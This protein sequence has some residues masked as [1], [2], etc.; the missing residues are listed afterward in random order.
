[1]RKLAT[2]ALAF[3]AAVFVA[4]YAFPTEWLFVAAILTAIPG[5]LLILFHRRWLTPVILALMFFS[6]GLVH[7]RLYVGRTLERAA[8]FDR[9]DVSVEGRLLDY[10]D[11][12]DGYTRLL[13]RIEDGEL[14]RFKAV[15]YDNDHL[16][17]GALP[18]DRILFEGSVRTADTLYGEPYDNYIVN[19]VFFRLTIKSG[20]VLTP[21]GFSLRT[22][23]V[24]LRRL[25]CSR[26]DAVFPADVRP[27]LKAL[28]LGDRDDFYADDALYVS[29]TRSGLMHVVAVS[30]LH[31]AFL[32]GLL[33]FILGRGKVGTLVS[34][35][36]V[37]LFVLVTGAGK[38]AVRAGFM[39]TLLLLA[40]ILRRENDPLTS[41]SAVLAL[42]LCASPFAAR[43]V[44]LQLSYTAMAGILC[45]FERIESAFE[46]HVPERFLCRPVRYL[47]ASVA[48]SL[49]VMPFTVPLTALHFGYVPLLSPISNPLCLWAVS[50]SFCGAWL[51]T[52]LS[53]IP[54]LGRAAGWLFAWPVRWLMLCARL[55]AA[56]PYAV[57]YMK[58][59][60]AWL[61]IAVSYALV[62]TALGMK[63]YRGLRFLM[64]GLI[65]LSL[66][67]G[68]FAYAWRDS[69]AI[70]T[71]SVLNVGQG[72]CI[73]AFAGDR[74]AVI[75]CGNTSNLDNAGMLAGEYLLSRGR[76][77]ID[78]L[79]LTHLHEDHADGAVR[80]MEMLP[81]DTLILPD[82]ADD[83]DGMYGRILACA[84]KNATHVEIIKDSS[85]LTVDGLS[86]ELFPPESGA[87]QNERCLMTL[88]HAGTLDVLVTADASKAMERKLVKRE[89]LS[90]ADILIVGHHGSKSSCSDELLQEVGGRTAVISVGYNRYGHPAQETIERLEKYGYQVFR[91]D[92]DGS[93]E[94]RAGGQYSEKERKNRGK[95]VLFRGALHSE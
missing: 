70:E 93:V 92:R 94:I 54:L 69:R 37:W 33:R 29:M 77:R 24:R 46:A 1:M 65:S 55:I 59:H 91:T 74:T 67:A 86:M 75:D 28:M 17:D 2:A 36:A 31:V 26:V 19:G 34:I 71:V 20:A 7:Y 72:Q 58:T 35:A 41:L 43:S 42:C 8:Q 16:L 83:R 6:L 87:K 12:Y 57:L 53:V 45:F 4:N 47:L 10:P 62:L 38:A 23:P 60:G 61:W 50:V 15:V 25:L 13:I 81:V 66:L 80:L 14:P 9:Q 52:A 56:F 79:M 84:E 63:R 27:F 90:A 18:G 89:D 5:V 30:G 73:T 82:D 64:T 76:T 95:T 68:I 40:P 39:Q 3:S 51:S 49:S 85:V 22:I 44:S 11:V 78:V 48:G 21:G 88:L 32:V